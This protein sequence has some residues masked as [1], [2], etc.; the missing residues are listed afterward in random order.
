MHISVVE[1]VEQLADYIQRTIDAYGRS[2]KM[3]RRISMALSIMRGLLISLAVVAAILAAPLLITVTPILVVISDILQTKTRL[4]EK[5]EK[6]NHLY[7]Q[8]KQLLS[9]IR[10][11]TG[12]EDTTD[13][14]KDIFQRAYDIQQQ[15]GFSQPFDKYMR[16]YGLN[17]FVTEVTT[18]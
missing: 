12:S 6:Y 4:I 9:M 11:R 10:A 7:V 14:I 5:R 16:L 2:Y 3:L 13:I 18:Q 1:N 15:E 8:Y 17:G